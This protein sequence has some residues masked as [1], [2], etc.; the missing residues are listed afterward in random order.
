MIPSHPIF[1]ACL[2][3]AFGSYIVWYARKTARDPKSYIDHWQAWLSQNRWA[4]RAVRVLA[5]VWM[6][7]GFLMISEGILEFVPLWT[8]RTPRTA[9]ALFIALIVVTF[10]SIP[11]QQQYPSR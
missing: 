4:Y 1:P 2:Y 10:F 9:F 8:S 6:W 3:V 7:S 11:K 5:M